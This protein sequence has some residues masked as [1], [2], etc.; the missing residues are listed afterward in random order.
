MKFRQLIQVRSCRATAAVLTKH[1]SIWERVPRFGQ[2]H[3]TVQERLGRIGRLLSYQEEDR[4]GLARSKA[5]LRQETI[6][7]ALTIA[8]QVKAWAYLRGDELVNARTSVTFSGLNDLHSKLPEHLR[9][10]H[11]LATRA[12][13]KGAEE[14]GLTQASLDKLGKRIS[15]LEEL[16][17]APQLANVERKTATSELAEEIS[18]L[19]EFLNEAVDPLM[20]QF[21]QDHPTFA[22][23][24]QNAR[25]IGGRQSREEVDGQGKAE[26]KSQ[27]EGEADVEA[28]TTAVTAEAELI[29]RETGASLTA[30]TSGNGAA[31]GLP[32]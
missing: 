31:A 25:R 28:E 8:G 2:L 15:A 4:R 26:P 23:E 5:K 29:R 22:S 24:Y 30:A 9:G 32:S 1:R 14:Y 10:I 17:L 27:E 21:R 13:A 20:R 19:L 11:E 7:L 18:A 12:L 3:S 6:D 16:N